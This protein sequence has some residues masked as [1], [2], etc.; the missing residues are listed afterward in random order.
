M[1]RFIALLAVVS[2]LL[3]VESKADDR[4]EWCIHSK[5]EAVE[6]IFGFAQQG[7]EIEAIEGLQAQTYLGL[8]REQVEVPNLPDV[9]IVF[10]T[11]PGRFVVGIVFSDTHRCG[12]F[13]LSW[14][15]HVIF[16]KK[17]RGET[18]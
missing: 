10:A 18:I 17:S 15:S 16:L 12:V 7:A 5:Q 13:R 4:K 1:T 6:Q 14:A 9:T 2:G 11:I 3:L 8:L